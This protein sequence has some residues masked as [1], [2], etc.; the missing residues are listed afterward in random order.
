MERA[1]VFFRPRY[2]LLFCAALGSTP[3]ITCDQFASRYHH[4]VAFFLTRCAAP[5]MG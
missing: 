2:M 1:P 3:T 4:G 5:L